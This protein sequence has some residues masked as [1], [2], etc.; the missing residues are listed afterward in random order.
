MLFAKNIFVNSKCFEL[1]RE[2]LHLH[3]QRKRTSGAIKDQLSC[4]SLCQ[5]VLKD[6]GSTSC[7]HV[8]CRPC[9]AS[10][11]EEC[12]SADFSCPQCGKRSRKSPELQT[13]SQ[14]STEP[15][16]YLLFLIQN[17]NI[18]AE[19]FTIDLPW[20]I[21]LPSP[22]CFCYLFFFCLS[23]SYRQSAGGFRQS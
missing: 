5:V 11:W 18:F 1:K 21:Q 4:C 14:N 6:P 13:P 9:I 17:Q 8:F 19:K 20:L 22:F 16:K 12:K 10:N 2:Y 23:S 7:G 15:S 3:R